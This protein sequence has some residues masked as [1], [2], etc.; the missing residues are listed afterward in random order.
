MGKSQSNLVVRDVEYKRCA[1]K[2]KGAVNEIELFNEELKNIIDGL[3]E[4]AVYDKLIA[5]I[6]VLKKIQVSNLI[7]ELGNLVDNIE[8]DTKSFIEQIDMKDDY[9]Y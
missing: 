4:N 8:E 6:L 5:S 3:V 9:F 1:R 2:I 7:G